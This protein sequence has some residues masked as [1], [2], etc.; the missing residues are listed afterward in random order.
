MIFVESPLSEVKRNFLPR[1]IVGRALILL[2]LFVPSKVFA[3]TAPEVLFNVGHLSGDCWTTPTM[4]LLSSGSRD[5]SGVWTENS[6]TYSDSS[7]A[8]AGSGSISMTV[9]MS[10]VRPSGTTGGAQYAGYG[11]EIWTKHPADMTITGSGS[12]SASF[13]GGAEGN[14]SFGPYPI[15]AGTYGLSQTS[16]QSGNTNSSGDQ[17]VNFTCST[18]ANYFSAYP[19]VTYYKAFKT[20][21]PL[22]KLSGTVTLGG[23]GA[24]SGIVTGSGLVGVT[25]A[26]AT[27]IAKIGFPGATIGYSVTLTNES[28]DPDGPGGTQGTC[29]AVWTNSGPS[30]TIT[31]SSSSNSSV[32]FTPNTAGTY[33]VDLTVTDNEGSQASTSFSFNPR[34]MSNPWPG[35]YGRTPEIVNGCPG[36]GNGDPTWFDTIANPISGA[37]AAR[38]HDPVKTRGFPLRLDAQINNQ[39]RLPTR[40]TALANAD[41]TYSIG[42]F[43]YQHYD[44]GGFMHRERYLVD[45]DGTTLYLGNWT[46]PPSLPSYFKASLNSNATVLSNAGPPGRISYAVNCTYKISGGALYRITDPRGNI[47]QTS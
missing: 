44:G 12:A 26:T 4:S 32:T 18:S 28:N 22:Y 16:G 45:A 46:D 13:T 23:T 21:G 31:P 38:Y 6:F 30:G 17:V 27:P 47:Q 3:Q 15:N 34:G 10:V 43:Y 25:Y 2:A 7:S 9:G 14:I 1:K 5:D 11:F 39:I 37:T 41:F 35:R 20:E 8:S 36:P 29:S 40:K 33:T 42:V 19:N 24:A